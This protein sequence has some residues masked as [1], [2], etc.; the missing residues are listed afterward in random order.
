MATDWK[1]ISNGKV[2]R[3]LWLVKDSDLLV[4]NPEF[5]TFNK[6]FKFVS[7]SKLRTNRILYIE[8]K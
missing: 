3:N 8:R 2:Q 1:I 4:K 6:K 7:I 5:E